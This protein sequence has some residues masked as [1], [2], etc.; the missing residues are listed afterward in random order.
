[1]SNLSKFIQVVEDSFEPMSWDLRAHQCH[2]FRLWK[3]AP[4]CPLP[5]TQGRKRGLYISHEM[6]SAGQSPSPWVSAAGPALGSPGTS[7]PI[8]SGSWPGSQGHLQHQQRRRPPTGSCQQRSYA[9]AP[10]WPPALAQPGKT[11]RFLCV[12]GSTA[13][14]T[15][16][17]CVEGGPMGGPVGGEEG[18]W[19][20]QKVTGW[21]FA[22]RF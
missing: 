1:M 3:H 14:E 19:Q 22:Y 17:V 6:Y 13:W 12:S 11:T 2:P 8:F 18:H 4:P 16:C 7:G 9:D 10:T 15:L 5:S 21:D 20:G